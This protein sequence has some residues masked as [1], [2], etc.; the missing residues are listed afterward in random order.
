M[1]YNPADTYLQEAE[2]LLAE[3]EEAALSLAGEKPGGER[4]NQLFRAFHTIKGS[5]AMCGFN[6]V[7]AF[8]HRVETVLD[9]VRQGSIPVSNTLAEAILSAKD[10]IRA[11]LAAGQ[12][13]EADARASTRD[14]V[15]LLD[16]LAGAGEPAPKSASKPADAPHGTG[17]VT[18]R[19]LFRPD[20]DLMIHGGRPAALIRDLR[21]LGECQVSAQTDR[22]PDL[23]EIDPERCYLGW[24]ITLRT[25]AG[26]DAIRDVFLFVEDGA[27]L[28]IEAVPEGS[29]APAVRAP[30]PRQGAAT[31]NALSRESTVRVP[32]ERLDRLVGLVGELVVNQ[33]RLAQ[34]AS[35]AGAPELAG[36]VE[37]I[38]RL[39]AELRDDVLGI[40]MMPIGSIFGRFRRLVHDLSAELGK[41][42]DLVTSGEETELDKS[43]LDQLGEPLVHLLRNSIDHGIG[44]P[45][46][47]AASGKPARGVIRLSALHTGSDVVVGVEDDGRGLDRAAIRAKAVEKQLI[48]ADAGLTGKEILNLILLP[49]FSTAGLVTSVSGRGVGMD[50]VKRQIDA[51]RGAI[52][53][54]SEPGKGTRISLRLPL[55]LAIIEGWLVEV[56]PD[57]FILPMAAVAEN[58]E[59]DRIQRA[60]NNGRNIV[61]VRGELIPYIDLREAFGLPGSPPAVEKV[62]VVHHEEHRVGLVVD[63]VLGTHQTVLQ[64]L[65]SFLRNVG[66]VSGSTV[67]GDGGV[68]LILDIRE[69]VR[70]AQRQGK[71]AQ[72]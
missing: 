28:E 13:G 26:R 49:G 25:G 34:A 63:R 20:P 9:L 6:Q 64:P 22:V 37:E 43:I 2:D 53:I 48:P 19:I 61:A 17:E 18:W 33:S 31:C 45:E 68:A 3:I 58:I 11:L 39:V 8:T 65:G 38:E 54:A 62:V 55:T 51:L 70:F 32:S 29:S 12:P 41:Q 4:L 71:R 59:L 23:D 35:H 14:L 1:Q 52:S 72:P 7:A 21:S 67:M 42:I 24:S 57:R 60:R 30:R 10:E 50:V 16:G 47:R 46:Q 27:T 15:A 40:R 69:I 36:P 5:G 44:T 66:V 56:G